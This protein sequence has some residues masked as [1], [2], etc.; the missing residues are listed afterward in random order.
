MGRKARRDDTAEAPVLAFPASGSVK[1]TTPWEKIARD[2]CNWDH[3]R[4]AAAFRAFCAGK[5]I[6]LN[7]A[8][9][10][11]VFT[12]FCASQPSI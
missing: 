2:N 6:K 7:A 5:K 11:T 3:G 8:N 1:Y 9:I 10:E 12:S 4:I